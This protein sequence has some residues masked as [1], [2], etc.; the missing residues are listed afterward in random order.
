MLRK[1]L[2]ETIQDLVIDSIVS[3]AVE[4]LL[5]AITSGLVL[6]FLSN[7]AFVAAALCVGCHIVMWWFIYRVISAEK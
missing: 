6:N 4:A 1:F 2:K 7:P 5:E 3:F